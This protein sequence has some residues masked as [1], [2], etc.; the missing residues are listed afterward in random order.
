MR[1]S[2]N[3][4]C[5]FIYA[6]QQIPLNWLRC[7][8]SIH[9]LQS[10]VLIRPVS[11]TLISILGK[12][13]HLPRLCSLTIEELCSV[14]DRTTIYRLILALPMLTYYKISTEY[15]NQSV[16]LPIYHLLVTDIETVLRV[17]QIHHL[18]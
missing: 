7:Y 8:S 9:H 14:K 6:C 16:S 17:T 13:I 2:T 11:D 10:I 12:L 3:K 18:V 5:Q 15:S 1:Y 4:Y